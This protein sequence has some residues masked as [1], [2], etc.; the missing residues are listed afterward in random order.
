MDDKPKSTADT[1]EP[2]DGSP[3]SPTDT[4][5]PARITSASSAPPEARADRPGG[6]LPDEVPLLP[7]R[8]SVAFPG[9]I[10]PLSIGRDR[11]KRLVESAVRG[12]KVI[13]VIAQ[14]HKETEEPGLD[15]IYRIGTACMILKLLTL[16]DGTQSI[17]VHGLNRIGVEA[18]TATDP[19]L[20][21]RIN[22]HEDVTETNP[23]IE[24]LVH[25]ARQSAYRLFQLSPSVPEEAR[26]VLDKIDTP[27]GVADFLAAN[28]SLE[29]VRRQ[30]LLETFDVRDR[31]RMV[32]RSLAE[33]L[34]VL[35]LSNKIQAR[36]R[37]QI[38]ES[39]KEYFLQEQLKAI[40]KELGEVD[41][42]RCPSRPARKSIASSRA[43]SAFR[44]RHPSIPSPSTTSPGCATCRGR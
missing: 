35:E 11:S 27:G 43:W 6:E 8:D 22:E 42:R 3:E 26:I 2:I 32:N 24:A 44:R 37:E 17:L 16:P 15:D 25:T 34:E 33:Q 41:A 10:M 12:D 5:V 36:V 31:L 21:A 14:R 18:L 30:E 28:L 1:G 23:E 7:L 9:T 4:I 29:L 40:Q 13:G 39:Q 38:D 20:V 19:F